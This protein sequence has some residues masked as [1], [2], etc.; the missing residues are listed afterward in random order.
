MCA[1]LRQ[2]NVCAREAPSP[3]SSL[4]VVH[5]SLS[6]RMNNPLKL[7]SLRYGA[8]LAIEEILCRDLGKDVLSGEFVQEILILPWVFFRDF[9]QKYCIQLILPRG[10]LQ[11]SCQQNCYKKIARTKRLSG[12]IL[13]QGLVK[14]TQMF[15]KDLKRA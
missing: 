15:L 1:Q 6:D 14:G 13:C 11:R 3:L 2:K 8:H 12:K 10:L 5:C 7:Q 4:V 9:M